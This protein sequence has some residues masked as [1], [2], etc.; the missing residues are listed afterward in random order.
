M[1][2]IKN[3]EIYTP[4][5]I[6]EKGNILINGT[7]ISRVSERPFSD[8]SS[9]AEIIDAAGK[10]V[11]PGFIDVHL[12]GAGGCDFL[13]GTKEALA[14]ICETLTRFGT[15]S[16]LATTVFKNS[17]NSHIENII[18]FMKKPRGANILGIHLEGPFINQKKKGMIR[19][20]GI[21]V[22][23][24]NYLNKIL[25]ITKGKLKMITIAP[26]LNGAIGVIKMLK[27]KKI[28]ASFGHSEATLTQ[29][30]KGIDAGITHATHIFNAM[31]PIHHRDPGPLAAILMDNRVSAQVICDGIHIHPDVI[32]LI[33]KL[34]G[35]RNIALITDSVSSLGL[36]NGEY[37]YDG[38][39]YKS[40]DGVCRYKDGTLIGTALPLNKMVKRMVKFGGVSLQEAIQMA[41]MNP[42]KILRVD[43]KKGSVEKG[44]DADLIIADKALNVFM[45][46]VGGKCVYRK[47]RQG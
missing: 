14:K 35:M 29:T 18:E 11:F 3:A 47:A 9:R 20:N 41:T 24:L 5:K 19:P 13:D 30:Q 23:S 42:A 36:R 26:E 1:L 37:I 38:W 21:K 45:T 34:K 17:K 32:R 25:K 27:K 28:I 31:R 15:T 16:L 43:D 8:L 7:K 46:L 12:Q 6:I 22:C 2:H 44:K 10:I 4:H 39:R 33:V 40:K